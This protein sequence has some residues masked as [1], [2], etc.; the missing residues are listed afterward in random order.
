MNRVRSLLN[1]EPGE[2]LPVFLL[3]LYL[4]LALT[5]F[6]VAKAVRDALFLN[7]FSATVLPYVTS[8]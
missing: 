3:F 7:Q 4:T 5:S 1:L 6:I 2:E 8:D